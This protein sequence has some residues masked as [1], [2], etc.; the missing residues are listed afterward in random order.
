MHILASFPNKISRLKRERFFFQK[1]KIL[2]PNTKRFG[3]SCFGG[4][5]TW[6]SPLPSPL[7][8]QRWDKIAN[9]NHQKGDKIKDP[10]HFKIV[11]PYTSLL[12]CKNSSK[13][14]SFAAMRPDWNWEEKEGKKISGIGLN[15]KFPTQTIDWVAMSEGSLGKH[16]ALTL[17][18][19]LTLH[20]S[21]GS[22]VDHFW[23]R[24]QCDDGVWLLSSFSQAGGEAWTDQGSWPSLLSFSF[25]TEAEWCWHVFLK[26]ER[27]CLDPF[28]C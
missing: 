23:S 15:F 11:S 9:G 3:G 19:L 2:P 4:C 26:G 25:F 24:K 16:L 21:W 8:L 12:W 14:H 10:V 28:V 27:K 5:M 6:T 17:D 20:L 22:A 18:D 7:D 13:M 1:L